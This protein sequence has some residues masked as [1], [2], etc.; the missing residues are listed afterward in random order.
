MSPWVSWG[1][2][3]H[4]ILFYFMLHRFIFHKGRMETNN[5]EPWWTNMDLRLGA[6]SFLTD[7][8]LN[9]GP[10]FYA[11]RYFLMRVYCWLVLECDSHFHP[12]RSVFFS[13]MTSAYLEFSAAKLWMWW[14][15]SYTTAR[16]QSWVPARARE[17]SVQ[18]GHTDLHRND[19]F[20]YTFI[21]TGDSFLE[22]WIQ[23]S[24]S[25]FLKV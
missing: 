16:R 24:F 11:V 5:R 14:A 20:R 3:A 8:L 15:G 2:Q 12:A 7:H 1:I 13:Q 22:S 23:T 18:T 4:L 9:L 17:A 21:S 25:P 10:G 19:E 6:S